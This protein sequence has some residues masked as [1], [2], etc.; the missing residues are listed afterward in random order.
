MD[1]FCDSEKKG[2]PSKADATQFGRAIKERKR[3][4]TAFKVYQCN[5]C[6][7]WHITTTYQSDVRERSRRKYAE[8]KDKYKS[9]Y[10]LVPPQEQQYKPKKKKVRR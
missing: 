6:S 8:R 1:T 5:L 3:D 4:K 7:Q 2:F 10:L 9:N